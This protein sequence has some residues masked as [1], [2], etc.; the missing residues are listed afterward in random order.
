VLLLPEARK[1]GLEKLVAVLSAQLGFSDAKSSDS[2]SLSASELLEAAK[3][4][5]ASLACSAICL[6]CCSS[7]PARSNLTLL[8]V[9]GAMLADFLNCWHAVRC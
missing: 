4:L 1:S 8:L 3:S 9:W 2:D 6:N 5:A 7:G